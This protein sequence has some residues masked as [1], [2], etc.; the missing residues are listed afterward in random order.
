MSAAT[1]HQ[2]MSHGCDRHPPFGNVLRNFGIGERKS[3]GG[4]NRLQKNDDTVYIVPVVRQDSVKQSISA[5]RNEQW[6]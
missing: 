1:N 5:I 3:I 6:N 2:R 4:Q